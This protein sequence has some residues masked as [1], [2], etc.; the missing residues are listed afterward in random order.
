MA[1]RFDAVAG[2]LLAVYGVELPGGEREGCIAETG[3]DEVLQ[4]AAPQVLVAPW[5]STSKLSSS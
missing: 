5:S 4:V 3:A 1:G 2:E